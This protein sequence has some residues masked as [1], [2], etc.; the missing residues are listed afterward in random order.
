MIFKMLMC[1]MMTEGVICGPYTSI[2]AHRHVAYLGRT[3][4]QNCRHRGQGDE[5]ETRLMQK[6]HL[7]PQHLKR[8]GRHSSAHDSP[9]TSTFQRSTALIGSPAGGHDS[10]WK[11]SKSS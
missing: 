6:L 4:E 7:G 5:T 8:A 2:F 9:H 10:L 11:E 1:A 3:M